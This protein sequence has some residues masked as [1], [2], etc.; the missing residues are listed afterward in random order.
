MPT[1][2]EKREILTC[3]DL[4]D[5]L[6]EYVEDGLDE[7]AKRWMDEH[8]HLCVDCVDYLVSYRATVAACREAYGEPG[9]SAANDDDCPELPE[10]LVQRILQA[11]AESDR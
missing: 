4:V 10:A 11:A 8:L 3:R 2:P 6:G 9:A 7:Q 1:P 5:R